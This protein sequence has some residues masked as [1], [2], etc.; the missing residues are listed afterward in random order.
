MQEAETIAA[1][2]SPAQWIEVRYEDYCRE[3]QAALRRLHRFLGVE[4]NKRIEDSCSRAQHVVGNGMRLD[5]MF[6][7]RLD[8]R[9][10]QELNERDLRAFDRIAGRMNRRYG[11]E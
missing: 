4:P 1:C 2:L 3:P 7:V 5:R 10:R 9:W 11:Y 6:E 8:E